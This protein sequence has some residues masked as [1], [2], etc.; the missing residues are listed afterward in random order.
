M[1]N[2]IIAIGLLICLAAFTGCKDEFGKKLFGPDETVAPEKVTDR[3]LTFL[4]TTGKTAVEEGSAVTATP[5]DV[6][7][8]QAQP[9]GEVAEIALSAKLDAKSFKDQ[10]FNVEVVEDENLLLQYRKEN[11]TRVKFLPALAYSLQTNLISIESRS[12]VAINQSI[13][14]VINSNAMEVNQDYLLAVKL[15]TQEGF[16]M[17]PD[18]QILYLHLKRKGGSGEMEGAAD[19]RPMSGDDALDPDGVDKGINRNNLYYETSG[20]PFKKMSTCTIE[21]LVYVDAFK[22]E[23]DRNDATLAGISSVWG[24]EA[25]GENVD[26]LLRFGD[27]GVSPNR[28]QLVLGS[29]K[30]VVDYN[31]R[32]KNWYHLAMTY[33]GSTVRFY[34]NGREKLSFSKTGDISLAGAMFRL[35][36]SFNQ[37]RGFNGMMSEVRIWNTARTIMELKM[38]A[39]DIIELDQA[40][41]NLLAYWKMNKV[42]DDSENQQIADISGKGHDLTVKRQGASNPSATPRVVINN[43]ID[44]NLK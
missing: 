26:F 25:G 10:T 42:K 27:S 7:F 2:K 3:V 21:G 1:K 6:I 38:N 30:Y 35:G 39:L 29:D 14:K 8:S 31:F 34:V 19:L 20:Q 18:N 37:W 43:N 4:N 11:G 12:T 36:Q 44:I 16:V 22:P 28:L 13:V 17:Q 41:S 24:Y 23:G 33:D 5:V 9:I 32:A 15:E 40:K